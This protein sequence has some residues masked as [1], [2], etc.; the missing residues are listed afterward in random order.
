MVWVL[1]P[2]SFPWMRINHITVAGF[3]VRGRNLRGRQ[4]QRL[5]VA[6]D[7]IFPAMM[8]VDRPSAGRGRYSPVIATALFPSAGRQKEKQIPEMNVF[9]LRFKPILIADLVV[10]TVW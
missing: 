5:G 1:F 4:A 6:V 8:L 9:Y 7:E 2:Q 3:P 10:G